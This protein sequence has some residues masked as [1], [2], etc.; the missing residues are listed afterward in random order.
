MRCP[1]ATGD[2][3]F[4][5]ANRT[6]AIDKVG[7]GPMKDDDSFWQAKA[8]AWDVSVDEAKT[9]RCG[10]CKVFNQ[11]DE[12][13]SCIAQ[14]SDKKAADTKGVGYCESLNFMCS[15]SN[16]C[17][18]WAP[19]NQKKVDVVELFLDRTK[20]LFAE[21]QKKTIK[22]GSF[23]EWNS[24]GGKA[25]GRVEHVMYEGTLGVP[26]SDFSINATEDDPAVLIRIWRDGKDGWGETETLVGHRMST[27][28]RIEALSKKTYDVEYLEGKATRKVRDSNYWGRPVGTP[29]T[30]GMKPEG[31]TSPIGRARAA[32]GGKPATAASR[33]SRRV[34]TSRSQKPSTS[35]SGGGKKP[36]SKPK[37]PSTGG[38]K[39]RRKPTVSR[40]GQI[41]VDQYNAE[42]E[43]LK[44]PKAQAA[45]R[46]IDDIIDKV[47]SEWRDDTPGKV[48]LGIGLSNRSKEIDTDGISDEERSVLREKF[49][50]IERDKVVDIFQPHLDNIAD[51][52]G[53]TSKPE[54]PKRRVRSNKDRV[55]RRVTVGVGTQA[56]D[57]IDKRKERAEERRQKAESEPNTS[58]VPA[59]EFSVEG[60]AAELKKISKDGREDGAGTEADP[61]YVGDDV[62]LA[63]QLLSEGK[64]IRMKDERAVSTLLDKLHET[65]KDAKEK[66]DKAPE[67]DLCKVSVSNTNLFCV[68]SKG[69][70]RVKMPQFKGTPVE[71]SYAD[72]KKNDKGE[73]DVE[74]EFRELLSALGISTEMKTVPASELKASQ[75]NLDG[76]KVV[77]MAQAMREGKIPDA[78][79][80]VTRDGYILDGHHRWAA[81]VAIDLDDGVS[82]DIDMPV[83]MIDAEIGYLIDLANGFTEIAGIRAKGLGA[84]AEAVDAG[85]LLQDAMERGRIEAG[86]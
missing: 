9:R 79:I 76:P 10:N 54:R 47:N 86:K 44:S 49:A 51:A 11:S 68:E 15:A 42:Q 65:V 69:I 36:P 20:R 12:M 34:S 45:G 23:V 72:T 25:R 58:V 56:Q 40:D 31:P 41:A 82:G 21:I 52:L 33:P 78:P 73:G 59:K 50:K 53:V 57:A 80:F 5:A 74:P 70:P 81:K 38:D 48:K 77:G 30:S 18:A 14:G 27:L 7:Y 39:P 37:A 8:E 26:D 29:I 13:K 4:N 3:E 67:Y 71:G 19:T 16:T 24:S 84:A 28:N 1:R 46:L 43:G 66:G 32:A 35:A 83:E 75:D 22:E 6:K 2:A 64:H 17:D 61:V 63:H 60:A 85:E 55:D 62:E